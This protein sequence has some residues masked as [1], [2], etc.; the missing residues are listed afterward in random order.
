M[1]LQIKER[2]LDST[3]LQQI[4]RVL[5]QGGIIVYPTETAYGLGC[6]AL[7]IKALKK[8]FELKQ[9]PQDQPLAVLVSSLEM[10]N[11]IAYLNDKALKLIECFHP[12]PLVIS[13]PKKA[14]IPD[15]LNPTGIA[16]RIS[17]YPIAD[18]IVRSLQKPLVSTS[19][20]ISGHPPPYSIEDV[21][22]SLEESAIDLILDA[23][24]LP[25]HKPSTLVDF[26]LKPT[27]QIIREGSISAKEILSTL[28]IPEKNW[29]KHYH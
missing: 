8:I 23:G 9:R 19:A 7:N 15:E 29:D 21:K 26:Q 17:S 12:G 2:K 18:Q 14:I 5:A 13:L 1:K 4:T 11:D 10:I 16:F 25:Y 22:N 3:I 6:D 24:E 27:P 20:N 28:Q